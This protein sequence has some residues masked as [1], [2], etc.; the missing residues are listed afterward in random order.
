M[1][2]NLRYIL[3]YV[4]LFLTFYMLVVLDLDGPIAGV[5]YNKHG[6]MSAT[7]VAVLRYG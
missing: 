1:L 6:S 3:K 5:R 4:N 2:W 7:V